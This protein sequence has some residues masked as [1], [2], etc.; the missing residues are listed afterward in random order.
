MSVLKLALLSSCLLLTACQT[1]S[2]RELSASE[3]NKAKTEQNKIS[4]AENGDLPAPQASHLRMYVF[5][6][7]QDEDEKNNKRDG[8]FIDFEVTNNQE[9]N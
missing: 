2:L 9:K 4:G 7:Y 3:P 1:T 8:Y 5:T 6:S